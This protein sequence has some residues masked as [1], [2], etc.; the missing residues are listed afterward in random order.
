MAFEPKLDAMKFEVQDDGLSATRI[1]VIGVGGGGANAVARMMGE[2]VT[3]VEFHIV[4]TDRQALEACPVPNKLAIGVKLTNG[5][6]AG[7]DPELGREAALEDTERIVEI[8]EGSDMVFVAAGL[9]GG[10]GTGAAPVV[11][12]LA[13]ELNA[14]TVAVVTRPFSFEGTQ[15]ARVAEKGLA[16]LAGTVD[17]VIAVCNDKLL[18]LAP[19]GTSVLDAFRLADDVLRQAVQGI[20]DVMTTPGVINRDFTDIKA[21]MAGMG[22]SM[23]GSGSAKGE[24]AAVE[25]AR[26]AIQCPLFDGNE[27]RGARRILIN[28]SGSGRLGL[29]DINEACTLIREAAGNDEVQINFGL[30]LNE[31]LGDAVKVTV[32]ATGCQPSAAPAPARARER[33]RRETPV[34][35][36]E[37]PLFQVGTPSAPPFEEEPRAEEARQPAPE[38]EPT[39]VAVVQPGEEPVDDDVDTPAFLR[40]GRRLFS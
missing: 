10:T 28:I 4:N 26:K 22:H 13:K 20:S 18:E 7:S 5:L 29:H 24:N 33:V 30:V 17:N 15:R 40:R 34:E 19:R 8:I 32:I 27:I 35:P 38:P 39:P 37:P 12:S 1:K 14:L 23:M 21:I 6:G 11:A 25:A 3:G 31:A 16:D 9:G 2:G 36:P